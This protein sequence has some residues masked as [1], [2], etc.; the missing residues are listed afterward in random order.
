MSS[1]YV[2]QLE[3]GKFYVGRSNNVSIRIDNH[4]IDD[5]S[6]KSAWTIKYKPIR[7]VETIHNCDV[8]DEDKYVLKYMN[9]YGIDNVRGGT[10]SQVVLSDTSV[11]T[12]NK[13]L[14]GANDQCFNCGS[15]GHFT[16]QCDTVIIEKETEKKESSLLYDVATFISWLLTPGKN[17]ACFR[18]GRTSHL[19]SKCYAKYH[20]NGRK[21]A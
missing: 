7:I 5:N 8:F 14:R 1:I 11:E 21:L 12:I 19:A 20:I 13:M 17:Y 3:N 10:F 15:E 4:F 2:L 6:K 18:C 16:S 9:K